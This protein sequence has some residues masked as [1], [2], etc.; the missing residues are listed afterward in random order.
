MR[1]L[2]GLLSI[3][4]TISL[5]GC[6][7]APAEE[8]KKVDTTPVVQE[9]A[10]NEDGYPQT[11]SEFL[12]YFDEALE[13][14]HPSEWL[15]S[16]E[17]PDQAESKTTKKR[18]TWVYSGDT[19]LNKDIWVE[20]RSP[21]LE[22]AYMGWQIKDTQSLTRDGLNIKTT[23]FEE[24]KEFAAENGTKDNGIEEMSSLTV[25]EDTVNGNSYQFFLTAPA[26]DFE[27]YNAFVEK[28]V[29]TFK[30][31]TEGGGGVAAD[32]SADNYP[33]APELE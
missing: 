29:G 9:E 25:I 28:A 6:T 1:K 22:T 13:F 33:K 4:A 20:F 8:E 15:M 19:E 32:E 17:K 31:Y 26:K 27:K 18:V 16:E 11:T 7:Q 10:V 24:D 5:S 30:V 23:V 21:M 12:P 2:A 3:L 14:S